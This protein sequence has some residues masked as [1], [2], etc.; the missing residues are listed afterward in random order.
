MRS[1]LALGLLIV[2]CAS[3]N[4]AR[5]HHS[6]PQHVFVRPSEDMIPSPDMIP[7]FGSPEW[8]RLHREDTPCY[9]DPSKLGG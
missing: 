3:A 9:D 7:A 2:L 8:A 6:G 1:A 4:A 5:L